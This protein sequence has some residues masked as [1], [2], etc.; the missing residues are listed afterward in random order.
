MS[1]CVEGTRTK[2]R[3]SRKAGTKKMIWPRRVMA[4]ATKFQIPGSKFQGNPRLQAPRDVSVHG[5]GA[6]WL[7]P[8][9][10]FGFGIRDF[11]QS[12]PREV[13]FF[14]RPIFR[15]LSQVEFARQ[16]LSAHFVKH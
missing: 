6:W 7:E 12:F 4:S 11:S 16:N 1:V 10:G 5:F 15:R 14:I 9:G 3:N 2:T 13:F 8:L